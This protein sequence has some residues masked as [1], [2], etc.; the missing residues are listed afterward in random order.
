VT[1]R[2]NGTEVLSLGRPIATN[3]SSAVV[4][5]RNVA[6]A[7]VTIALVAMGAQAQVATPATSP[8]GASAHDLAKKLSNPVAALISVS[9][10]PN[11]DRGIG[12]ADEGVRW[13]PGVDVCS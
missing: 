11:H 8:A 5:L 13:A 9:F 2:R 3:R 12:S 7:V 10:Q 1:P 6:V 4:R